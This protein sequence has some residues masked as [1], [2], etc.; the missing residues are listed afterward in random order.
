V[1]EPVEVTQGGRQAPPVQTPEQQSSAEAQAPPEGWQAAGG[2]HFQAP[3]RS[4]HEAGAQHDGSS[5]PAQAPPL[6]VQAEEVAQRSTP[7]APGTHGTPSQHWSRNWQTLPGWMQ[8]AG[9]AASQPEGQVASTGPP[10]QRMIPFESALQ[11]ALPLPV[12]SWQQFCE[13]FTVPLP[14]QMLPGGLQ[15]V[16]FVQVKSSLVEVSGLVEPAA[17]QKTPY[18]PWPPQQDSLPSQ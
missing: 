10:K 15:L 7:S 13:A 3:A 4:W 5:A 14:P 8:Q 11:T 9:L 16:P 12:P 1:H 17:S 2:S 18:P 6:G